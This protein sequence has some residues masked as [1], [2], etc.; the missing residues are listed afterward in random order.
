[1]KDKDN[2]NKKNE[3]RSLLNTKEND[4]KKFIRNN[5]AM[6][7]RN[8][9]FNSPNDSI[10]SI[11]NKTSIKNILKKNK[12]NKKVVNFLKNKKKS[13]KGKFWNENKLVSF[14][15]I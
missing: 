2:D 3:K 6:N 12:N 11:I 14:S 13:I 1:L 10:S 15:Q 7:L 8:K 4:E 9:S 5:S